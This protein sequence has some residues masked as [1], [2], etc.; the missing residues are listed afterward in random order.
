MANFF[1]LIQSKI[2]KCPRIEWQ[3]QYIFIRLI[4]SNIR[5]KLENLPFTSSP[6]RNRSHPLNRI[7]SPKI[8]SK[9]SSKLSLPNSMYVPCERNFEEQTIAQPMCVATN[10]DDMDTR[11]VKA[12]FITDIRWKLKELFNQHDEHSARKKMK[13]SK[14]DEILS[15]GWMMKQQHDQD[16]VGKNKSVH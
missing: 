12:S 2:E 4:E 13:T 3:L 1:R 6:P 8:C 7:F 15:P 14:R 10:P 16:I 11:T 5:L 9:N